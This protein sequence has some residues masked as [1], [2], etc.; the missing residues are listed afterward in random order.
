[1]KRITTLLFFLLFVSSIAF[2]QSGKMNVGQINL[3]MGVSFYQ[4]KHMSYDKLNRMSV[5]PANHTRNLEGLTEEATAMTA[6]AGLYLS[7]SL[8]QGVNN[9]LRLGF[10]VHSDKEAMVSFK[11]EDLDTSIV[12]CNLQSEFALEGSYIWKGRWG[13]RWHWHL[14]A[15]LS[16]GITYGNKMMIL[17]GEYFEPGLHPSSQEVSMGEPEVFKAKSSFYTRL[18]IPAGI[19]YKLGR[20]SIGIDIRKGKGLQ[21][22]KGEKVSYLSRTGAFI[23]ST[24]YY[25]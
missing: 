16:T 6:G 1:M 13:K 3:G 23:L 12:F 11:N 18:Y 22:M 7:L 25:L 2:S 15:G 19:H 10:A 21:F 14:G 8:N 4:Y 9:E 20:M 5:N 17:E 24:R